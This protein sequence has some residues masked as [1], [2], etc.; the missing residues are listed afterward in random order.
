MTRTPSFIDFKRVNLK[1]KWRKVLIAMP[2]RRRGRFAQEIS[3]K[4]IVR[5]ARCLLAHRNREHKTNHGS[6]EPPLAAEMQVNPD[7]LALARRALELLPDPCRIGLGSGRTTAAFIHYLGEE[8]K[9]GKRVRAVPTSQTTANL[10]RSLG[11]PL[12]TLESD[13]PLDVTIDGADE[14]RPDTLDA[15]KGWGAALT[16]ERVVAA[17]SKQQVLIVTA[18]KLVSRLGERGRLPVE[19]LPFA[20]PFCRCR[21]EALSAPG[22]LR[23][24]IRGGDQPVLTDNGNWVL[25]V[26]VPPLDDPATLNRDLLAIPGV[27]DTGFFLGTASM[28]LVARDGRVD[29]LRR[30]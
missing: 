21:I 29:E 27:I 1:Y 22:G 20:A 10:A 7:Y 19:V 15:V 30:P 17:A 6:Y 26:Q 28:V 11:I 8:V 14:V 24:R 25:D 2:I 9:R 5:V 23:V 3:N 18:E 4:P 13:E 12:D 16:R